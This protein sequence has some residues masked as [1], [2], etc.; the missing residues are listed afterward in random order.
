MP[1]INCPKLSQTSKHHL[2]SFVSPLQDRYTLV[3][4]LRKNLLLYSSK[5]SLGVYQ[6]AGYLLQ[7]N[8]FSGTIITAPSITLCQLHASSSFFS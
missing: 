6:L 5:P 1:Y 7:A 2:Q 8:K 3:S 4:L